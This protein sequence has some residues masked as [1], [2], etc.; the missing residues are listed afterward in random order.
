MERVESFW[1]IFLSMMIF[2]FV[3][4]ALS[5]N[6]LI[7][8]QAPQW[9]NQQW[10]NSPPL[11]LSQLKGRVVLLRFFMESSCPMCRASAPY[12]NEFYSAYKDDGLV[13]IGMYT[14]KPYPQKTAVET[15]ERFVKDY[16]FQFPVAVDD[17]WATLKKFW[18]NHVPDA[19]FTSVSFLIDRKGRIQYI[20]QGGAYTHQDAVVLKKRIEQLI[21]QS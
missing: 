7:G 5:G 2:A 11:T 8:S 17:D 1:Y 13:V 18:L 6:N 10:L 9:T 4:L 20:H 14:P 3:M 21:E 19:D 16:G 12:L 15:V